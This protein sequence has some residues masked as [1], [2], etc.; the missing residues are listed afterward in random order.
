MRKRTI[1]TDRYNT[2]KPKELR[3]LYEPLGVLY[4]LTTKGATKPRRIFPPRGQGISIMQ[5]RRDFVDA[6]A[7]LGTYTKE[8]GIAVALER[9]PGGL[10]LRVAGTGDIDGKVVPFL[11]DL[12]HLLSAIVKLQKDEVEGEVKERILLSLADI[13]LDFAQEKAF[14][15]YMKLLHHIAPVCLTDMTS[16]LNDPYKDPNDFKA[17]FQENFY[18]KGAPLAQGDMKLLAKECFKARQSGLI[19]SLREFTYQGHEHV[20]YFE[21]FYKQI[22]KLSLT[23][24]MT[25]QLLESAISLRQDL[26]NDLAAESIP[27]SPGLPIPLLPR[28]LTMEGIAHR[29][30]SD[31]SRSD[32]FLQK[33][34]QTAPP[35][36]T[37]TLADY[38]HTVLT[39]VH[40]EL[41]VINY[42]DSLSD[43]GFIDEG[44][45]YIACTKPSCYLCHLF[46]S[47]HPAGYS[48]ISSNS[49]LCLNWRLPDI[50]HQE[51]NAMTRAKNQRSILQQ[52]I[53]TI[54]I[55]LERKVKNEWIL[56]PH[57]TESET[58]WTLSI[59]DET[60][61]YS[62]QPTSPELTPGYPIAS[63]ELLTS[64]R[65]TS[66]DE[67]SG[68]GKGTDQDAE[69]VVVFKGRCRF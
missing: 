48:M 37:N 26:A 24:D 13:A 20:T 39:E 44:D 29:M 23:I 45:K 28:K 33:L 22:R 65:D 25:S 67:M 15:H 55:E 19:N 61:D 4:E 57:C 68:R 5:R 32:D 31:P 8:C 12:L 1:S 21:K 18:K 34:Q 56:Q 40:P 53:N 52:L 51:C 43:G 36:L 66:S 11:N 7:F 3:R 6:V 17:W 60:L 58:E 47:Y 27:S 2:H 42:F 10:I 59:D 49:R 38:S 30:F 14:A 9:Q 69:D 62:L 63:T 46:I 16:E 64:E 41:L 50:S 35:G 54:R